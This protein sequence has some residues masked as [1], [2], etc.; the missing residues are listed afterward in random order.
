MSNVEC[1]ATYLLLK[2]HQRCDKLR[3]A[4]LI[5]ALHVQL[6]EVAEPAAKQ[7][8]LEEVSRWITEVGNGR[9]A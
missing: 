6:S 9:R 1:G 7:W 4:M 2:H 8:S 5:K 3:T